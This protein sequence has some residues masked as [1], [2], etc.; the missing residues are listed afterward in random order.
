MERSF[1]D[2]ELRFARHLDMMPREISERIFLPAL[3][4]CVRNPNN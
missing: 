3:V 1:A 2:F 4:S